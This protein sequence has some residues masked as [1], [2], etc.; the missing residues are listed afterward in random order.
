MGDYYIKLVPETVNK[1]ESR[2]IADKVI[3]NLI[4]KK[5]ILAEQTD[6]VLGQEKGYPPAVNSKKVVEDSEHIFS[7]M[8]NGLAI[9]MGKQVFYSDGPDELRCPN[10]NHDIIDVE[11]GEALS[12]WV[13]ETGK[14]KVT[15]TKCEQANSI[16]KCIFDPPWAFGEIGFIFWNWG[17][18]FKGFFLIDLENLT[19]HKFKV[20]Y[21]KL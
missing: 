5:I 19:G 20:V 4:D 7:Y 12:E 17:S 2:R 14:D 6:C 11:W 1:E 3:K 18:C 13:N 8:T 15:C 9:E 21:G 10:C 16:S